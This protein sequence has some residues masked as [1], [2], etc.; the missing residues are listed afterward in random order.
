M[1]GGGGCFCQLRLFLFIIPSV[2]SL[3]HYVLLLGFPVSVDAAQIAY[4]SLRIYMNG[5]HISV[6]H[7]SFMRRVFSGIHSSEE[8]KLH[9]TPIRLRVTVSSYGRINRCIEHAFIH[10]L[11]KAFCD[12]SLKGAPTGSWFWPRV[13]MPI[14]QTVWWSKCVL[15]HVISQTSIHP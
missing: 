12:S 11:I 14:Y 3:C 7:L 5:P 6:W 10:R 1:Y 2:Y 8:E 15:K 4:S 13:V 9:E